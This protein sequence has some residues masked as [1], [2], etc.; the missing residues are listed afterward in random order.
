MDR[1]S[2]RHDNEGFVTGG[3]PLDLS[4][5]RERLRLL[6]SI[7]R[8]TADML[9]VMHKTE[10]KTP[11]PERAPA[12]QITQLSAS[13][14]RLAQVNAANDA[15][16]RAQRAQ[17][18]ARDEL[19][20]FLP[21]TPASD[22]RA[23]VQSS[24]AASADVAAPVPVSAPAPAPLQAREPSAR[25]N[26][27]PILAETAETPQRGA[28]GR[29]VGR[30]NGGNGESDSESRQKEESRTSRIL[31]K[32]KDMFG[33]AR[34]GISGAADGY[35]QVDPAIGAAKEASGIVSPL[36]RPVKGLLGLIRR[37]GKDLE[38]AERKVVVPWYRRIWDQLRDLNKKTGRESGG[39]LISKGF[40]LIMGLLRRIPGFGLLDK[41]VKGVAGL[42]GRALGGLGGIGGKIA[43]F[44][45][46]LGKLALPL[47]G[48]LAA[49]KG[50]NTSTEEY[51][52]RLGVELNG[53]LAQELGVR[54]VG[55]LGDL[56]N[57]LTFGLA[58][59]FG[60]L[61]SPYLQPVFE[62]IGKAW[63]A[64][65]E[66]FQTAWA[67]VTSGV[68]KSWDAVTSG[69]A[70]A[71]DDIKSSATKVFD[72]IGDWIDEKLGRVKDVGK[73]VANKAGEAWQGAKDTASSAASTV[74]D[75]ASSAYEAATI[76]GGRLV[77]SLDKG[78]RHKETFD[79]IKGGEQ[80]AKMGSYTNEEAARIRELK[81]TGANTTG[82]LKGG[83]PLDV[84]NKI[85]ASAKAAGLNPQDMLDMANIES[86]GNANA[87]SSTGAIGVYQM[88][89]RT[90]T[91]LGI[92][93]RF[94][95]DQNIEGGMKLAQQ[96]AA[97]LK[98]AG[99]PVNRDSLYMLHQLGPTAGVDLLK[100]AAQ[101]KSMNELSTLT[102][103]SAA[104]NVGKGSKTAAEYLAAN[105]KALDARL[106]KGKA[107]LPAGI[108]APG[109]P[110]A[111]DPAPKAMPAVARV[112][113][114][115]E[116]LRVTPVPA[117]P[118]P[119]ASNDKPA[120]PAPLTVELPLTQNLSD[121]GLA[122]AATGGVGMQ[123]GVR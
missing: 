104:L 72:G 100:G 120:A 79:G 93:D 27:A 73:A 35:E 54:F 65:M 116:N 2:L 98:K 10:R 91:G 69:I 102:Q 26:R 106:N 97:V 75:K 29:F 37:P 14:R 7:K 74:K 76:A 82:S 110:A 1:L 53:S 123:A 21:S 34:D 63:D 36:M 33:G 9:D 89:G 4:G 32:L 51:A 103:S 45:G 117:I 87:I 18:R 38:N 46:P 48:M 49:V 109:A 108:A 24:A 90:A 68:T 112:A 118:K 13:I 113:P 47:A 67:G 88:T 6:R 92:T 40:G 78:Y 28:N 25:R 121:R 60:E 3:T 86:G 105:H 44:L 101:G 8:D 59:K 42:A 16:M 94:D 43:K 5:E 20:R 107:D 96:N 19:G 56:G 58:G 77:G 111:I 83:M 80:L 119:L 12:S 114:A 57:L 95:V 71:W 70:K 52:K 39:G 61:I 62:G 41:G 84:Q 50:F 17:S 31:G 22:L 11:V 81:T 23:P 115:A 122:H 85:I 55:V 30:G 15:V 66:W 99:L 64:S